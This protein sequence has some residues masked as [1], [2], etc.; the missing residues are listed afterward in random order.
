MKIPSNMYAF[1]CSGYIGIGIL[2]FPTLGLDVI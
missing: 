1:Q 2:L